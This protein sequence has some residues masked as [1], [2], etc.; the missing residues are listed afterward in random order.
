MNACLTPLSGIDGCHI[1]TVEGIGRSK[2]EL[3]PV[4]AS[5]ADVASC[6][7]AGELPL[8]CC[9]SCA[10]HRGVDHADRPLQPAI[11]GDAPPSC[12][13]PSLRPGG[14][15]HGSQRVVRIE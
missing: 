7:A 13:P 8:G 12:A 3:H 2:T 1:I 9:S 10:L 15:P 6:N 14:K 5:A 4:Q 11:H